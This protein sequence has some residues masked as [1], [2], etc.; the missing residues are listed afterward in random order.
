MSTDRRIGFWIA[1]SL[2]MGNMIGSGVFLL[3]ASLAPYGGISILGWVFTAT[4]A[5]LLALSFARF[6]RILPR[7]GG[8]YAYTRE[9]FG[10]FAAFLVAWTH[11]IAST[12]G[13]AAIATAFVGYLGVFLPG[14]SAPAVSALSALVVIWLLT[15]VNALGVRETGIVQ[16]VTTV[17]KLTPL[18]LI[19][20][21]GLFHF[22]AAHFQPFNP[23]GA[24]PLAALTATATLTLWAFV[25]IESA[26]IPAE[27]VRD[28]SRTIFRATV[29]GTIATAAVYILSTMAVMGVIP[30][31]RLAVSTA[32]FADAASRL[33]GGPAAYLVAVGAAI[34]SFGA[35]N[36]WILMQAQVPMAAARDGLFPAFFGK[37]SRRGTPVM[38][39]IVSS[40][41]VTVLMA[42]NFTKGLVERFTFIILLSTLATLIPYLFTAAAELAV[43]LRAPRTAGEGV[44]A[45]AG[46]GVVILALLAFL[47]AF[48]AIGGAGQEAVYWGFLLL[49]AGIP[50]YLWTVR[51]RVVGKR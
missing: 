30:L 20:L 7:T 45:T 4:G 31:D 21:F 39:L 44:T 28:P 1:T 10:D 22:Q 11:W 41:L 5:L 42:M 24:S 23:S 49:L 27:N 40:S 8:P 12:T 51:G 16:L 50:V 13:N 15:G 9:A 43:R 25:G 46:R 26:T 32:P 35:L 48:W 19:S 36:G 2:V 29:A 33:W 34:S 18:V 47:Y 3:P 6:S 37:L 17:L 14:L 38:G